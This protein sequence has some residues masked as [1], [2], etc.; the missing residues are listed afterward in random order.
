MDDAAWQQAEE[1]RLRRQR[2]EEQQ[3]QMA[4]PEKLR[5]NALQWE[6]LREE[7]V[8]LGPCPKRPALERDLVRCSVV[9]RPLAQVLEEQR[10]EA[11]KVILAMQAQLRDIT[12]QTGALSEY[13]RFAP[14]PPQPRKREVERVA[15]D[16]QDS[17][18]VADG[19]PS[20]AKLQASAPTTQPRPTLSTIPQSKFRP[21]EEKMC[22]NCAVL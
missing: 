18:S 17:D 15:T 7:I 13:R 8:A 10:V 22:D 21:R 4:D 2:E 6:R 16:W 14:P 5:L 11:E 1:E 20:R 9:R 3:R 19:Q 12:A